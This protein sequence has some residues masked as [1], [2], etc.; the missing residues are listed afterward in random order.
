MEIPLQAYQSV[1]KQFTT[2]MS[3]NRN[4]FLSIATKSAGKSIFQG[5]IFNFAF[6]KIPNINSAMSV[7]CGIVGLPNAGK[8]T[9]FNSLTNANVPTENF[10]YTTTESKIGS[11]AVPDERLF[12][13]AEMEKPQKTIPNTLEVTDIAGLAKG[14][15]EGEGLGN[16]FLDA[17]RNTDA[18]IHIIRCFDDDNVLHINTTIDPVRDKEEVDIELQFKDLE[19]VGKILIKAEKSVRAGDKEIL[20]FHDILLRLKAQLEQGKSIRDLH[21]PEEEN[22]MIRGYNFLSNKNTLYVANVNSD[23][24]S[25]SKYVDQLREAIK[26]EK[27]E[28]LILNAKLEA[29]IVEIEDPEEKKEFLE[30]YEISEPGVNRLIKSAYHLLDLISFFTVG[31]KEVRAWPVRKNMKAPQAAGV[32]HSDFERG[33]IRAEMMKYEDYIKYGS[34]QAC[35]DAARF[36]VVG[37]EYIVEDGDILHFRFNV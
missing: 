31:P 14:A 24:A 23:T 25:C 7:R 16:S 36:H 9:L 10:P 6:F 12:K 34:E 8:S 18:T 37:K 1:S 29:E 13:L 2:E 17:I 4:D 35:K 30:M 19:T 15:S 20:K 28:L 3:D 27:A 11:V 5:K 33:F 22:K 21:L 26:N 32:I